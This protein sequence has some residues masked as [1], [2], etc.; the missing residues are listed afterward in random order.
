MTGI[1]TTAVISILTTIIGYRYG[2]RKNKA[3]ANQIEIN[4]IKDVISIYT[5]TIQDLKNEVSE[6]KEQIKEYKS[7]IDNLENELQEMKAQMNKKP[8]KQTA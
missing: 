7:C 4:N 8:K 2:L 5:Q 3:E 6:L 1:I